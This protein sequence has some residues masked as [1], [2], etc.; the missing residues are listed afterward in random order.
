MKQ[1]ILITG[2]SGMVGNYFSSSSKAVLLSKKELD[3]TNFKQVNEVIQSLRPRAVINLA[4]LTNVDYCET[5]PWETYQINTHGAAN[6]A[7]ACRINDAFLIQV[8]TGGVFSGTRQ[9]AYTV[10][11]K[12]DPVSVYARSKYLAEIVCQDIQ[13]QSA[14]VRTGWIFG[15][16]EKD[17]KFVGLIAQQI[18]SGAIEISAIT[19]TTGCPTYA[20]DLAQSLLSLAE[21]RQSGLH[22]VIN[23]GHATR[24]EMACYIARCLNPEVKVKAVKPTKLENFSA[25]RPK[26]EVIVPTVAMRSW[27]QAM[28][29][30][31]EVWKN[32]HEL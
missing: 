17:K 6:V 12:P 13:P 22:H 31:L 10:Q 7:E 19:E 4:A 8:S 1:T 20:Y 15:G 2:A 11:D 30:Y 18:Y 29:E 16:N 28:K 23:T 5:H 27:K 24:Y 26:Y 32:S 25:P 3:V 21:K 14:V 9:R